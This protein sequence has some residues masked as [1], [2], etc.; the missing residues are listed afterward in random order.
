M[1]AGQL[2]MHA[3]DAMQLNHIAGSNAPS[4]MDLQLY[5]VRLDNLR[6]RSRNKATCACLLV[7]SVRL[8]PDPGVQLKLSCQP[9]APL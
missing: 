4:T 8:D 3:D 1:Q 6:F 9:D 7:H 5:Q 2:M